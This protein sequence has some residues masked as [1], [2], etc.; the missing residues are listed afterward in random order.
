MNRIKQTLLLALMATS[1]SAGAQ[2]KVGFAYDEAGNRVKR[3][4]VITRSANMENDSPE[5]SESFYDAL[6]DRTVKISP[7]SYGI[8][9]VSVLH[10]LPTDDGNVGVYAVSGTEILR[11]RI[12]GAETVVD[13]SNQPQGVYILRVII[14]G[15][16]TTWKITKK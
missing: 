9:N 3:E 10:M 13:I 11:Q 2:G 4:I 16:S 14:N 1:L 6:G 8:I 12:T 15:T 5:K 7:N